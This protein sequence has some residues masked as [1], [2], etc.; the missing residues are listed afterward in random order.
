MVVGFASMMLQTPPASLED[1]AERPATL[2]GMAAQ[3]TRGIVD[4]RLVLGVLDE[5][6]KDNIIFFLINHNYHINPRK[7]NG[8]LAG[9]W[10]TWMNCSKPKGSSR[11]ACNVFSET[12][13]KTGPGC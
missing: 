7:M 2:P 6:K 4:E 8:W 12:F 13:V 9:S 5:V 10:P 11:I 3:R 1:A